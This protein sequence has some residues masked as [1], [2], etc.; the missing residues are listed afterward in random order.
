M[1]VSKVDGH[2][3]DVP[4]EQVDLRAVISTSLERT[5]TVGLTFLVQV[6]TPACP[7]AANLA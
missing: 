6:L 1:R 2:N 5:A 3:D 7:A 4:L